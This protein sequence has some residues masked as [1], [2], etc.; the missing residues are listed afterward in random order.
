MILIVNLVRTA[1]SANLICC[2]WRNLWCDCH[3]THTP[4][5]KWASQN[6]ANCGLTILIVSV[7]PVQL[8][9][10]DKA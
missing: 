6:K 1:P 3:V 5:C 2:W 10:Y 8:T 4:K 9:N 7:F